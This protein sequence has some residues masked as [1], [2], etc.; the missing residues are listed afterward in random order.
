MVPMRVRDDG[1]LDRF[2]G[3][4]VKIPG[5]AIQPVRGDDYELFGI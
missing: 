1:V 5:R 3:I 4:D 2:P